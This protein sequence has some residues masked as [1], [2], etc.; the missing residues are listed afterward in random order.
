MPSSSSSSAKPVTVDVWSSLE[1]EKGGDSSVQ[2]GK[3]AASGGGLESFVLFVGGHQSGKSS[4]IS[5]FLNPTRDSKPLPTTALE[6][7]FGRRSNT[8][9]TDKDVAHIWE[10]GGGISLAGLIDVPITPQRLSTAVA[11][12]VVDMSRPGDVVS[13]A[14]TW[15]GLLR[16]RVAECMEKMTKKTPEAAEALHAATAA[17]LGLEGHVDARK[18]SPLPIPV[19]VLGAKYDVFQN[20]DPAV[21][22]PVVSALR[23]VS[24]LHGASFFAVSGKL[25]QTM[26]CFRAW[27]NHFVFRLEP[28]GVAKTKV[29]EGEAPPL[30]PPGSDTFESIGCPPGVG[31][32]DIMVGS[33]E[34]RVKPWAQWVASMHPPTPPD[35]SAAAAGSAGAGGGDEG[36]DGSATAWPEAAVDRMAAQKAEELAR[37]VREAERRM[38]LEA[39][40]SGLVGKAGGKARGAS[41][42]TK[43]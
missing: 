36:G 34:D 18:L 21:R 7:T 42:R 20:L 27:M 23:F 14:M 37:Y 40:A 33:V 43:A 16:K 4:L 39:R 25:R 28:K 35:D 5:H 13:D 17:R 3:G 30:V 22:R 10:L 41:K 1:A 9:T 32:S 26:S 31:E 8:A 24:H 29:V 6:Y 19:M 38:K 12:V 2:G 15:L 11:V